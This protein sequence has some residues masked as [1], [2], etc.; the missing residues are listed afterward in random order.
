MYD[1]VMLIV[2][3]WFDKGIIFSPSYLAVLKIYI[4]NLT[5]LSIIYVSRSRHLMLL[6]I[7]GGR[8]FRD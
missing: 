4:L 6:A 5:F 8:E 3:M 1:F 7:E 2:G